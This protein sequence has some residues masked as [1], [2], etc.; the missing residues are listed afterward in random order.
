MI[1]HVVKPGESLYSISRMYDV[2]FNK[3]ATDNEIINP[4]RLVVGQALVILEETRRHIVLANQS[5]YTIASSYG[6]TISE[7]IAANPQMVNPSLIYPGQIINIPSSTKKIGTIEVNG[8][9][10][11]NINMD[12]LQ[13]TLPYLTYLSIFSYEVKEDGTLSNI[14]DT[15]LIEAARQANV[16]PLMIITNLLPE[17]GF[18]SDLANSILSNEQIQDKLLDNVLQILRTKNYYGLGIDFEYIYPQDRELYNNFV[19][20]AV[21]KLTPLGFTVTTALAPKISSDQKGLLYEAHD[22]PVHGE[23]VSHVILMTYEWGYTYSPPMA[24]SPINA[25]RRVLNY[26]VTAIP[27]DKILMGIPNYGYDWT[28]PYQ[29]GTRATTVSNVGAVNLAARYWAEI[30]YDQVSQAPYFN[31]Y[32]ENGKE[33]VVWFDDARS[34]KAKLE[35]ANEFKLSGVS[36]WTINRYFSQNWLVLNSLYNIKKVNL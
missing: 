29:P 5:L 34:I 36:Y 17:G 28:L 35:L 3:I 16:A 14:N 8:Y 9:A 2:P 13:K 32:D 26:A 31:Y 11:P 1:I 25:V 24:V 7:L 22:Y 19:R 6:L 10:F 30:K 18:S 4:S 27:R 21:Q 15:P 20:K 12:V 23:L 33:H